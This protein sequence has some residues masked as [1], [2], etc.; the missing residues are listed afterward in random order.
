VVSPGYAAPAATGL[1]TGAGALASTIDPS[2]SVRSVAPN[3]KPPKAKTELTAKRGMFTST[4]ANSNGTF[5]TDFA[6]ERL[7]Y[8]DSNGAWQPIDTSLTSDASVAGYTYRGKANDLGLRVNTKNPS[9]SLVQATYGAYKIGLRVPTV[10]SAGNSTSATGFSFA[11]TGKSNL[12]IDSRPSGFEFGAT[13][14]S[15]S[16][17]AVY[18]FAISAG[19][20]LVSLEAD[21]QTVDF[22]DPAANGGAGEVVATIDAP[23]LVDASGVSG[24]VT[25]ALN[26]SAAG[27]NAGETMLT[28]SLDP[29]WLAAAGRAFPVSFDPTTTY[30]YCI[31]NGAT[32]CTQNQSSGGTDALIQSAYPDATATFTRMRIGTSADSGY[33]WGLMRELVY[34]PNV[35]LGDGAQVDA[36][37]LNLYEYTNYGSGQKLISYPMAKTWN[38]SNA[39][40]NNQAGNYYSSPAGVATTVDTSKQA[41]GCGSGWVCQDVTDIVRGWYSRDLANWFSNTGFQVRLVTESQAE[42]RFDNNANAPTGKAPAL[43]I[44]YS[45]PN[46]KI[47]FDSADGKATGL[48]PNWA[49]STFYTSE[50]ANLP[51]VITNN[52]GYTLNSTS[53]S[54]YYSFGYRWFDSTGKL[55][56]SELGDLPN[57]ISNGVSTDGEGT[58][59]PVPWLAVN[60]PSTPGQY[61]LRLDVVHWYGSDSNPIWSSD[62]AEPTLYYAQ[63]KANAMTSNVHWAGN[64]VIERDEYSVSVVS[65]AGAGVG[66]TKSLNLPSGGTLGLN[67]W[68]SNVNMTADSGIGFSDLGGSVGLGYQFN[69][70]D[71]AYCTGVLKSCGWTTT[72]DQGF[73]S[74]GYGG[75]LFRDADGTVYSVDPNSHGQLMGLPY[76]ANR[77]RVTLWDENTVGGWS[78]GPGV[79]STQ[80]YPTSD[81]SGHSMYV[82]AAAAAT[83]TSAIPKVNLAQYPLLYLAGV[84]QSSSAGLGI[85]FTVKDSK[86]GVSKKISYVFGPNFSMGADI[87]KN[88]LTAAWTTWTSLTSANAPNVWSDIT[89]SLSIWTSSSLNP[90]AISDP[91]VVTAVAL[92]TSGSSGYGYYDTVRF[93]SGGSTLAD[94]SLPNFTPSGSATLISTDAYQGTHSIAVLPAQT[95]TSGQTVNMSQYPY[96]SWAWRKQGGSSVAITFNFTDTKANTTNLP[97]SITYY[98][99]ARLASYGSNAIQVSPTVPQNWT[100]VRRD[101]DDDARTV[102]GYYTNSD[103]TGSNNQP[104]SGPTP[105]PISMTGYTLIAGDGTWAHFDAIAADSLPDP[106]NQVGMSHGDDFGITMAGGVQHRFDQDGYLTSILT[107]SPTGT[108]YKTAIAWTYDFTQKPG[109]HTLSSITAPS[110]G[111][112]LSS[113]TARRRILVQNDANS[114]GNGAVTCGWSGANKHCV[115]FTEQLGSTS[116]YSGRYAEFDYAASTVD[117]K[118]DLL[119]VI[120][121]RLSAPCAATGP[122]GCLTIAYDP[123]TA[124][125]LVTAYDPRYDGSNLDHTSVLYDLGLP[126]GIVDDA[127]VDNEI[128]VYMYEGIGSGA[129]AEVQ[130]ADSAANALGMARFTD[131]DPN[132]AVRAEW[133][134]KLCPNGGICG[135]YM[136]PDNL[137]TSYQTDGLGHYTETTTYRTGGANAVSY[138]T[139]QGTYAA[140]YV[141]NYSDPLAASEVLWTQSAEQYAASAAVGNYDLYRT[142]YAYN[143]LYERTDTFSQHAMGP[144]PTASYDATVLATS[145]LADFWRFNNGATDS[146]PGGHNGSGSITYQAPGAI[147]NDPQGDHNAAKVGSSSS[148]SVG[149]LGLSGTFTIEAWVQPTSVLAGTTLGILGSVTANNFGFDLSLTNGNLLHADIGDGTKWLTQTADAALPYNSSS[150]YHIVYVVEP[151]AYYAYVNGVL[152][153]D[154]TFAAASTPLLSDANHLVAIGNTGVGGSANFSGLIDD[155]S[156]Y[157]RALGYSEIVN[158]YELAG[159]FVPQDSHTSYEANG[160]PTGSNDAFIFNGSFEAGITATD[161]IG[162]TGGSLDCTTANSG[163]CSLKTSGAASASQSLRLV[164]GQTFRVQFATKA[165]AG[166]ARWSI[167]SSGTP[168]PIA[169]GSSSAASWGTRVVTGANGGSDLVVPLNSDGVVTVTL[170]TSAGETA[171]FDDV[172]VFTQYSATTY[173]TSTNG[174][175]ASDTD[176]NGVV[177]AYGY[178]ASASVPAIFATSVVANSGGTG[179]AN[180]ANVTSHT[181]YDPWGRTTSTTDPDGVV[182]TTHYAA[183]MTDIDYTA[184][185]L[186]NRTNN[187]FDAV[188]NKLTVTPPNGSA[189]TTTTTY[190]YENQVLT[191]TPP[192]DAT[193]HH[194]VTTNDYTSYGQLDYSIAD[195]SGLAVETKYIYDEY[196]RTLETIA[197]YTGVAATNDTSYDLAGNVVTTT[198]YP[199]NKSDGRTTTTFYDAAGSAVATQAPIAPGGSAPACPGSG[200]GQCDGLATIAFDGTKPK[201]LDAYGVATLNWSNLAGAPVQTVV[202]YVTGTYSAAH[203]DQD[204]TTSTAYDILGHA[205][206]AT[207]TLGDATETRYDALGRTIAILRWDSAH[208][209]AI[210]NRT[211]YT[212]GGRTWKVSRPGATTSGTITDTTVAWTETVYD[213]D[214]RAYATL[215]NYDVSGTGDTWAGRVNAGAYLE[216]FEGDTGSSPTD[217]SSSTD[218]LVGPST[219]TLDTTTAKTGSASYKVTTSGSANSGVKWALSADRYG[220]F[221]FRG[222]HSYHLHAD[223][224]GPSGHTLQAALGVAASGGYCA[225]LGSVALSGSW[226]TLDCTWTPAADTTSGVEAVIRQSDASAISFWLDNV[227]VFESDGSGNPLTSPPTNVA[228]VTAFNADGHV[229]HSTLAPGHLGSSASTGE[230]GIA[231]TVTAYD[232]LGRVVS[233]T[234]AALA[235]GESGSADRN[236]TTSYVY[237]GLGRK[238]D[239]TDPAG[240]I[241]HATYDGLGRLTSGMSNYVAG[242]GMTVS[243]NVTALA[244]YDDIGEAL[245]TCSADAVAAGCSAANIAT[246][247]LAWHY[248]YDLAGH[249]QRAVPPVNAHLAALDETVAIYDSAA[250]RVVSVVSC[251]ASAGSSCTVASNADRHTDTAYDALGRATSSNVYAGTTTSNPQLTSMTAYDGLGHT[252]SVRFSAPTQASANTIESVYDSFGRVTAMYEGTNAPGNPPSDGNAQTEAAT[253]NPDGT[254]ATRSDYAIGSTASVYTYDTLGRLTNA[255]SPTFAAG[256]SVSF[257]WRPDGLMDTR[258]WSTGPAKLV[259]AYDGAK[260]PIA[261]CNGT[262]GACAGA[263]IDI[264]R[265]YYPNGNVKTEIQNLLTGADPS[266]NG[267]QNFVYDNLGR[268]T[269]SSINDGQ[270]Y[271][272]DKAY[273]YDSDGNRLTV[274]VGGVPTDTFTFD[275]TDETVSDTHGGT[276]TSFTFDRYGNLLTS[277]TA[278]AATT[279]YAYDLADRLDSITQAD[280]S[281]VGFTFDAAGRHATRT[282]GTGQNMTTIDTYAY[283]GTS[284]SV[285][286][287]VSST[288]GTINAGIDAMDDRLSSSSTGGFAWIVPDLHGNVAAQCS[289]SG[290]VIDVFR[291]DA[292]G[293]ALGT[294]LAP[295]GVPSPWRF[296]GRILESTAGSATYDF[297]ARAYVP[298]L[299]TFTSLDSVA[300]SAQNPLTL[301]RYLYALANPETLVDPDGHGTPNC[302]GV[303]PDEIAQCEAAGGGS[304]PPPNCDNANP[305]DIQQCENAGGGTPTPTPKSSPP[306]GSNGSSGGPTSQGSAPGGSLCDYVHSDASCTPRPSLLS[307]GDEFAYLKS[308]G[309][310]RETIFIAGCM[311]NQSLAICLRGAQ[312]QY[313]NTGSGD[314]KALL[315]PI[316]VLFGV[317]IVVSAVGVVIGAVLVPAAVAGVTVCSTDDEVCEDIASDGVTP[318]EDI[319]AAVTDPAT[320]EVEQFST[321]ITKP[322]VTDPDLQN[323]VND[324]YKPGAQVGT[325]STAD[326]IRW[327]LQ[328]GQLVGGTDHQAKGLQY[329]SALVNWLAAHPDA[330]EGDKEVAQMIANDLL[331]ALGQ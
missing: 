16:D 112:S 306:T 97:G 75:Y 265:T 110:D 270:S 57:D 326:A 67:L 253:Y 269:S 274:T 95:A 301:N 199:N 54:D 151:G 329:I 56:A 168:N 320:A 323:L 238:T 7:N 319:T 145:G 2:V 100:L 117:G 275:A 317:A 194:S 247:N 206:V 180:V 207:D 48:G 213:A 291:Y 300:G 163:T 40:W 142:S 193:G 190:D 284:N 137:L 80:Y 24:A 267:V 28:Y 166:S 218:Y 125:V 321:G 241:T 116:S 58:D 196:G 158:R 322:T 62:F 195:S 204:V 220:T 134:P 328:T 8:K 296:E 307:W 109:S 3:A 224:E 64:S 279:T 278:A 63:A 9:A 249:Q 302:D 71:T 256:V 287:D 18:S 83:T 277:G 66:E 61:T 152:A 271:A 217:W 202:N 215:A 318:T 281:T 268:V 251:P 240:V 111:A 226:Q 33:P 42:V 147:A 133:A 124:H 146:G 6:L 10:S 4:Y 216:G 201:T 32:G 233:V 324:L 96:M 106:G 15:A 242:Q 1:S 161:T 35:V 235:G 227:Q 13:L 103:T 212:P 171:N 91:F 175:K 52:S 46:V 234:T 311:R 21:G 164:P 94:E 243:Q 239:V 69:S 150:W 273:T 86:T 99:G 285:L 93:E 108:P 309:A 208:A 115:R 294:P 130:W 272:V 210:W 316:A 308:I 59:P 84:V 105:D 50:V 185:D 264:E 197:D 143:S 183:N 325:G 259:F 31:M 78:S 310:S 298:D 159:D 138:I 27:L 98:A 187:T 282:S 257:T 263:A 280:G 156:I 198:A 104:S 118:N 255:T 184:D 177:T 304:A 122:R 39:T 214:G 131:I 79:S 245:A 5:T 205:I 114:N 30:T 102:L 11:D 37:S 92:D 135:A 17:P 181:V 19:S 178:A 250:Q 314:I 237:D 157:S 55:V 186:G 289:G 141:N 179:G 229:V 288:S 68:D 113:G 254:I 43:V 219:A 107:P 169:W 236:L 119:A 211:D 260:R 12:T 60:A 81:P 167:T 293:N 189:E 162:W 53:G 123:Y 121:G 232:N 330:S 136:I 222:G 327:T 129:F 51:L 101:L 315:E 44:T 292:Y 82:S 22:T 65:G 172:A 154:G 128:Y 297:G 45:I 252:L 312:E 34:F 188:G 283:L 303:P 29:A 230:T 76:T 258:S 244:A 228:T 248:Y 331:D 90:A 174:T 173:N 127:E 132:G 148:L 20:L 49:P 14:N 126:S 299:G 23:S 176:A 120:P 209:S 191:V 290:S 36:A 77:Y 221:L 73:T 286:Q 246:S 165:S 88:P 182:A 38:S 41:S 262:A 149:N 89:A 313:G 225:T 295:S 266:Q 231:T 155:V 70:L 25:V 87:A 139:R 276:D 47:A 144:T 153:G 261:E 200:N 74:D 170:S 160:Y 203:P 305:N 72:Y 85:M 223:V 26:A 192:A 140:A